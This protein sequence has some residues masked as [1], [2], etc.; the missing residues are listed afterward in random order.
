MLESEK[1]EPPL[2]LVTLTV[3]LGLSMAIIDTTIVNVALTNMAGNL[4]ATS[5]EIAWVATGYI[6][7]NVVIMPL[8]GWL[9]ALLG[10]Q[11]FYAISLAIFTIASLLCGTARDVTTLVIYRVIQGIGGGALQPTAQSILFESF[12]MEKRGQ[13]MAIFGIGAMV[14]PAIGPTLGGWLVDN[15]SW[16]LI[17]LINIP[18]GCV[19][20]FMTLAFIR[21]PSYIKKPERGADWTGL[22]AMTIGIASLQY[23]L[24][25]GQRADWFNSS[26]IVILSIVSVVM[27]TFFIVREL[28]DPHPF[29]DLRVFRSPSFA[30]GNIIGVI[31]GFGLYG[32]NLV[33]PLFYQTVLGF[34]A[35]QT[36][37]A[38]LPGAVATAISMLIATLSQRRIGTRATIVIGLLLFTWGCW[39]MGSLNQ[40]VG[41]WDVFWPRGVQGFALGFIFVPLSTATLAAVDRADLPNASGLYTL[42]RQL[43]GGIGIAVLELLEQWREESAHAALAGSVALSNPNIARMFGGG[44]G[45]HAQVLSQLNGMVTQNAMLIAYNYVFRVCALI[46]LF[47]IPTVFLFKSDRP[48]APEQTPPPA[49]L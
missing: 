34:N 1:A 37:L 16:P 32:L 39:W 22:G 13:G 15:Y 7:A 36:G 4:G 45:N 3:M 49:E 30:A 2:A 33:L 48:I 38:L 46:F 26:S 17:F 23:V 14:G 31:T 41:Y 6:L 10:R 18:I 20:F 25:R 8:N 40:Y 44:T 47:S 19:A 21:D 9:T 24:E 43:G 28:R 42:I 27:L 35:M 12:P 29:V 5:D 11:K